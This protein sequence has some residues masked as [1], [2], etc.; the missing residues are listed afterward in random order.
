LYTEFCTGGD[1]SAQGFTQVLAGAF[2]KRIEQPDG[3]FVAD[4]DICPWALLCLFTSWADKPWLVNACVDVRI[5]V[6]H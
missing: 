2:G 1:R 5:Q 6:R 3:A 4:E